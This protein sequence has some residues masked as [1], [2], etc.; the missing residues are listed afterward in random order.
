MTYSLSDLQK[1]FRA[2]QSQAALTEL[3][4]LLETDARAGAVA[5][6]RRCA[7]GL[8]KLEAETQRMHK[9]FARRAHLVLQGAQWIA[10]V[11][12][13]GVGP[14]VGPVVAAAVILP[15]KPDLPGLNDSKKLTAATRERLDQA[16][17]EQA[18]SFCIAEV[19]PPTIDKLNIYHAALEAMRRA[20]VGLAKAPDHVFVDAR[21]IPKIQVPQTPIVH[22]D[23]E[24]GSIAAASILAKVYRDQQ[25]QELHT[26]FPEYGFDRNM[27]YPTQ[28]HREALEKLGALPEH[29]RSFGP[30]AAARMRELS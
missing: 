4:S 11:D 10:G 27:G 9:L 16:I 5:L 20:V 7:K 8:E 23:A 12:E 15:D 18:V 29:R 13:V 6:A 17:R 26:R 21:T 14:L 3:Q 19:D 1:R 30:V 28:E 22:G 24:E 25:M 2:A